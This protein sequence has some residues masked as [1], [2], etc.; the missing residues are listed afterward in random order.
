MQELRECLDI[1]RLRDALRDLPKTLE[2]TYERI[3][4]GIP[5]RY[6]PETI[7]IL[8]FVT[9]S[10]HPMHLTEVIEAIAVRP[11]ESPSFDHNWTLPDPREVVK[12]CPGLVSV[13]EE[14]LQLAHFSVKEYLMCPR[15]QP[16]FRQ[17]LAEIPATTA[18]TQIC[19]AY[20]THIAKVTD[21]RAFKSDGLEEDLSKQHLKRL[22]CVDDIKIRFKLLEHVARYWMAYADHSSIS[23]PMRKQVSEFLYTQKKALRLIFTLKYRLEDARADILAYRVDNPIYSAAEEGASRIVDLLAEYGADINAHGGTYGTALKVASYEGQKSTVRL[24]LEHGASVNVQ[25]GE[26]GNALQAASC[27][28]SESIVRLL[29][30][31]GAF[32]NAQGGYFGSALQAASCMGHESIVRLFLEQG[33]NV[34]IQGGPLG[35]PLIAAIVTN[36]KEIVQ[37]LVEYD[38]DLN[39]E[40]PNGNALYAAANRDYT[41]LA[42]LLLN[43]GANVNHKCGRFGSALE[44]ATWCGFSDMVKMLLDHGAD[45]NAMGPEG[46]ALHIAARQGYQ[47]LAQMLV[48]HGADIDARGRYGSALQAAVERHNRRVV[49]MLVDRGANNDARGPDADAL[50][51]QP[52]RINHKEIL[53]LLLIKGSNSDDRRVFLDNALIATASTGFDSAVELLL[54]HG[55]GVYTEGHLN[56]ALDAA[57]RGNRHSTEQLLQDA[58]A[59]ESVLWK[60]IKLRMKHMPKS[61]SSMSSAA[62]LNSAPTIMNTL[63]TVRDESSLDM[64]AQEGPISASNISAY[65]RKRSTDADEPLSPSTAE[66]PSR[67]TKLK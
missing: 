4:T 44:V 25:G 30:E 2:E 47:M 27:R 52:S 29:L 38:A 17:S 35:T 1:R 37:V 7:K 39:A 41:T 16:N 26:Y 63:S 48:D 53:R 5:E 45:I 64:D 62:G 12:L 9:Y 3:L 11:D 59:R 21:L 13:V 28:G 60:R 50:L 56:M 51:Y 54:E 10:K 24:L 15:L 67:R 33:A 31:R 40:G 22:E 6:V 18:I 49:Q 20:A 66:R 23:E 32:I 46:S 8:Q 19:I 36:E 57:R 58:I 34:N 42:G 14:H 61:N 55:H 65:K 43:S